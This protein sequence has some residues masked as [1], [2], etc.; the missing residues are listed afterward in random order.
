MPLTLPRRSLA[1]LLASAALTRHA[2]AQAPTAPGP[3]E[4]SQVPPGAPSIPTVGNL[5]EVATFSMQVTG[6]AV[7]PNGRIFVNFPRWEQDVPISVAEL[8]AGGQLTP[9]PNAE[10]N[11]WTDAKPLST[12]D[13]FVCVQSVTIDP[14]GFL[15]AL[16]PAAPGNSFNL[17]GG[18]KAVKI[19]LASNRVVR[20]YPFDRTVCPQGSYLNDIRFSPDARTAYLTDSGVIGALLVLDVATGQIRRLLANDPR[21]QVDKS[22]K[23]IADGTALKKADGQDPEFAADGIAVNRAGTALYW[24]ALTGDTLYTIPTAALRDPKLPEPKLA[25][26]IRTLGKTC[27]SDGYWI[28]RKDRLLITSPL[29]NSVKL[30]RPDGSLQVIVQD[31]RLRWPDSMAEGA[32]GTMFV[33]ASHIQDMAQFTGKPRTAPT[34]LFKFTPPA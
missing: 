34:A 3:S 14:A 23:V 31:P 21:T 15:W 1:A 19:D 25:A 16:D 18:P 30:R 12:A 4:P 17:P 24:Q 33:T 26:A 13:H 28:D 5:T 20:T 8:H 10:W 6:V 27:V 9:Y 2:Q 22:V 11:A 29:D 7:A 32:D